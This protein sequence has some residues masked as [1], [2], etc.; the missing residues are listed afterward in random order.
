[1]AFGWRPPPA[2]YVPAPI[3]LKNNPYK[4]RKQWPPDFETLDLKQQ[5]RL[6]KTFR[7]RSRLAF[8]NERWNNGVLIVRR[9]A[10]IVLTI[11]F[12]FFGQIE[13]GT[14]FDPVS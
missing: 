13:G 14:P 5:F 3:T 9:V 1:M 2:P 6:E 10:M 11:Y 8:T 4:A 7:R 12:V